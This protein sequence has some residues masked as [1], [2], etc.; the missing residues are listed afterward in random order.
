MKQFKPSLE[1]VM[2]DL[3]GFSHEIIMYVYH[4]LNGR[5]EEAQTY[6]DTHK[7]EQE[8]MKKELC[9]MTEEEMKKYGE[10]QE[11]EQKPKVEFEDMKLEFNNIEL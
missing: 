2:K 5:D 3:D 8:Q 9:V 1:K 6:L 10:E 7:E 4:K 11:K